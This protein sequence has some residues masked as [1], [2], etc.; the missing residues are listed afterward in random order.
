MLFQTGWN[1]K[2][3]DSFALENHEQTWDF[4]WK[5]KTQMLHGTAI[6]TSILLKFTVFM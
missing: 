4:D 2:L 6:L 5:V 1:H 3:V